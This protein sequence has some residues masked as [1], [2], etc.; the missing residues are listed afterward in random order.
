MKRRSFFIAATTL[1][2]VSLVSCDRDDYMQLPPTPPER[3]VKKLRASENDFQ[4]F[5]Y[6]TGKNLT[7]YTSQWQTSPQGGITRVDFQYEYEGTKLKKMT[8]QAGRVEYSY[9]GNR[10]TKSENFLNNGRKISSH[11]FTYDNNGRVTDLIETIDQPEDILEVKIHISYRGD[12][13]VARIDYFHKRVGE[14]VFENSFSKVFEDYDG[15]PNP[16][17]SALLEHFIPGQVLFKN[18]PKVIRNLDGNSTTSDILRITYQ[19]DDYG[20]PTLRDQ[21]IEI[22]GVLKPVIRYNYEY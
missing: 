21:Q 6:N 15:Q 10:L 13:N 20:Y 9:T 2:A 4:A 22:G 18:N 17:P 8:S 19:Y 3:Q 14:T 12:G 7:G 5:S 11:H 1:F 16:V